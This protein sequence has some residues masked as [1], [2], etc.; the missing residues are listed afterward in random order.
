MDK[1]ESKQLCRIYGQNVKAYRLKLEFT[2]E[3]FAARL[4][5]TQPYVAKIEAGRAWPHAPMF[6]RIAATLMVKPPELLKSRKKHER[7]D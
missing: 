2:Q 3:Q 7:S 6:T 1:K 5:I 4:G